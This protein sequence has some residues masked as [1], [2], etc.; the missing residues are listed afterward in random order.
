MYLT[1]FITLVATLC[2]AILTTLSAILCCFRMSNQPMKVGL[3][4]YAIPRDIRYG[5]NSGG[6]NL[7]STLKEILKE[8]SRGPQSYRE[9]FHALL[10]LEELQMEVDIRRY[11]LTGAEMKK[12]ANLLSLEVRRTIEKRRLL[13]FL[14]IIFVTREKSC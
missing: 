10:Y 3:Q 8:G 7:S 5:I 11:D 6:E 9:K 4:E 14:W 13:C 12:T 2:F 1:L